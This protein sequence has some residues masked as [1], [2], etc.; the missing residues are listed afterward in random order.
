M[1]PQ[2]SSERTKS[3]MEE[4]LHSITEKLLSQNRI[5]S[6]IHPTKILSPVRWHTPETLVSA[7]TFKRPY[8]WYTES[9]WILLSAPQS[10]V[11]KGRIASAKS[12]NKITLGGI[13]LVFFHN[14]CP[15]SPHWTW[16]L[17][18]RSWTGAA[19]VRG[20]INTNVCN[21]PVHVSD[22]EIWTA[23][24]RRSTL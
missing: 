7:V 3:N 19:P 13:V 11:G 10:R 9:R 20:L 6:L 14:R 24:F 1:E 21:V 4:I 2:I 15:V 12:R 23:I 5:S 18:A 22:T 16:R 17:V 8:P